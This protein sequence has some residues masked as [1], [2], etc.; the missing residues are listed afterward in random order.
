[1]YWRTK[2]IKNRIAEVLSEQNKSIYWLAQET[3]V[4]Y[5]TMHKIV[6]NKTES[7]RFETMEG[8][9]DALNCSIG[10]LFLIIKNDK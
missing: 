7:I 3:K 9:C 6:N 5:Q 2:M 10:E 4:T 1:M 8:I